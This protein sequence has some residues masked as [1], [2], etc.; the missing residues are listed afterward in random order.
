MNNILSI[1]GVSKSFGSKK[2]LDE[3]SFDVP[4]HEGFKLRGFIYGGD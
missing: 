1:K 3:L 4:R 2:I